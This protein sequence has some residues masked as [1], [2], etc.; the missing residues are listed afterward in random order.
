MAYSFSVSNRFIEKEGESYFS[1]SVQGP[2]SN[3]NIEM[4]VSARKAAELYD[5]GEENSVIKGLEGEIER[6][7]AML[8]Q[9]DSDMKDANSKKKQSLTLERS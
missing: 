2:K 7:G 5:Y 6:V 4:G 9:I 1:F 3:I 8:R